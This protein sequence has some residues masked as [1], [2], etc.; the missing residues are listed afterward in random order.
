[1]AVV[2]PAALLNAASKEGTA[3]GS[4]IIWGFDPAFAVANAA[5]KYHRPVIMMIGSRDAET[6]LGGYDNVRALVDCVTRKI[7]VPVA[8]HADH[9]SDFDSIVRAIQGGFTSV[10]IDASKFPLEENIRIVKEVVKVAHAAHVSVEAE[11]GRLPGNEGDEDVSVEEAFQTKPEEAVYF[12]EQ[13]GIDALAVAIGTMHGAYPP[14]VTPKLN[15]PLVKKLHSHV[16]VPLVMHGGSGTPDE[17]FRAV[18][19][20][21]IAKINVATDLVTATAKELAAIQ[22]KPNFRYNVENT[23][24]FGRSACQRSVEEKIRLFSGL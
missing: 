12:V 3:I 9:F 4:F 21:G 1:M 18:I 15:I 22:A 5:E 24:Y 19:K 14:G 8:L 23:F 11:L 2:S 7:S 16:P 13:T 20:A 17:K 10:M 6:Y